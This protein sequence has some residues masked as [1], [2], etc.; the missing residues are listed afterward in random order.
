MQTRR[1]LNFIHVMLKTIRVKRVTEEIIS[2]IH[3]QIAR[4]ELTAGDRLPSEREMAQ[5]LGVSRPTLREAMQVL[6]H[7]GFVKIIQGSGIYI[8]DIG[9]EDLTTW[10][11]SQF[12]GEIS[13]PAA[14]Y[15]MVVVSFIFTRRPLPQECRL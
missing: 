4:G 5:Q 13:C 11:I 2:Q 6:E 10:P 7:T 1:V 12:L 9:K 14:H 3:D 8:K 15:L